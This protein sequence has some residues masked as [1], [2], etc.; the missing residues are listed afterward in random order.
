MFAKIFKPTSEKIFVASVPFI[1]IV[2]VVAYVVLNFFFNLTASTWGNVFSAVAFLC[3]NF[4]SLFA[5]PFEGLLGLLGM[6]EYGG[7]IFEYQVLGANFAGM[8]LTQ[9]IYAVIFYAI[10]SVR[11]FIRS[12]KKMK[13][14]FGARG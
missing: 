6:L 1:V 3:Y 7:G 8:L 14:I 11:I 4:I 2:P 10:F 9:A 5:I 13:H 12:G